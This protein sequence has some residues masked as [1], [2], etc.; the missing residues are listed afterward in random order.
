MDPIAGLPRSGLRSCLDAGEIDFEQFRAQAE[1]R[2]TMLAVVARCQDASRLGVAMADVR[3][4]PDLAQL[5]IDSPSSRVRQLAAERIDEP[6]QLRR[7]L[8]QV[9]DKDKN[10][11]KILKQKCDALNAADRRAAANAA[12]IEALCASIERHSMKSFDSHYAGTLHHLSGRW[13]ALPVPPAEGFTQ[14]AAA[15]LARGR[16]VIE[17][18]LRQLE[19][20]AAQ[21]AAEQ[22][23]RLAARDAD[24]MA[25][26]AARE[27]EQAASDAQSEQQRQAA[28]AQELEL[29]AA[30]ERRAAEE[31]A[32]RKIGALVRTAN[33]ALNDG[34]TQRAA[35]L[36]RAIAERLQSA[37]VLPVF[38]TRQLEQLDGKL[39]DLKQWKEYAVAP[40]RVELIEEMESLIGSS[41]EP[42]PLSE[43]IKALQ[44]DWRT[45]GKGIV[46]E[47]PDEWERFHRASQ[48]AYEPCRIYFEAQAKLRKENLQSAPCV[49]GTTVGIRI[50]SARAANGLAAVFEGAARGAT[51]V[52]A[53]F[54]GG[55]RGGARGADPIRAIHA[56]L[57][58]QA[59]RL[60]RRQCGR[61]ASPD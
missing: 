2:S 55:A 51:G 61:Q 11:Y 24:E 59:R 18:H 22:A 3:T 57:A 46:A 45:I 35:G 38:L 43:R 23:E 19:Q 6:E 58:R 31:Q 50:Q 33:A 10:V 12:E 9:R 17:A 8:K 26:Q 16:D 20:Q 48:A 53:V 25:R 39:T 52:A 28:A 40:K 41:E 37:P 60:V 42:K 54:P 32:W 4:A 44:E 49:V 56:T 36:R 5:V 14:R 13:Q 21:Q 7:L 30:A 29:Q 34:S 15:A 1:N 27:A 47:A